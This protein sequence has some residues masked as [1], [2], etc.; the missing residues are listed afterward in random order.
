M[1]STRTKIILIAGSSVF[2]ILGLAW[3]AWSTFITLK[4][5]P[6]VEQQAGVGQLQTVIKLWA[7][8]APFTI[9]GTMKVPEGKKVTDDT[10]QGVVYTVQI[11]DAL[12]GSSATKLASD[13]SA[14]AGI[15]I[16]SSSDVT[17]EPETKLAR[18]T[19]VPREITDT[20]IQLLEVQY[21][22]V[23]VTTLSSAAPVDIVITLGTGN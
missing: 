17:D 21:S 10:E 2:L 13:I 20:L 7:D 12:G 3:E 18:K 9:E 4:T 14:I 5:Q 11:R 8:K 1:I 15:E 16:V 23:E 22:S 6:T 19:A